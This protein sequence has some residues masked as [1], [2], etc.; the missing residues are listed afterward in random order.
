[1]VTPPPSPPPQKA[2]KEKKKKIHKECATTKAIFAESV[3]KKLAEPPPPEPEMAATTEEEGDTVD[4]EIPWSEEELRMVF[5][6][7]DKD[8]DNELEVD[9]L[10]AL[11]RY[12]GAKPEPKDVAKLIKELTHYATIEWDEFMEFIRRFRELDLSILRQ[13]FK[14]AD[15]DG[16]GK[17]D[18]AEVQVLLRNMGYAPTEQTVH[19]AMDQVDSDKTGDINFREFEA[20]REYLRQTEGLN[21]ADIQGISELYLRANGGKKHDLATQEVWRI[22]MFRGYSNTPAEIAEIV[23]EVDADGSGS[24][25]FAELLKI[26]RRV[27]EIERDD[28]LRLLRK[29][30]DISGDRV[31][32]ADIVIVLN[33]L[34]YYVSEE[35]VAE[36]MESVL[37]GSDKDFLTLEELMAFLRAYRQCEGFSVEEMSE[38]TAA[39]VAEDIGKTNSVNALELGRVLRSFGFFRTLQKVQ[40]LVEEIDFD[41]S[42]ELEMNEYLKLMRQLLQGEAKKRRDVFDSLDPGR[43]GQVSVDLLPRAVTILDEVTPDREL[44]HMALSAALP[45][46]SFSINIGNFE[47][48]YKHYRKAVVEEIRKNAGYGPKE[49]IQLS[50]I[51]A[52]YDKDKSGTIERSELQKMIAQYFPDATKSRA[53][54]VEIQKVL[55]SLDTGAKSGELDFHKFVWLMRKCDDMRDKTDVL[56]EAEVVKACELTVEEVEGFRQIFS[57]VVDWTGELHLSELKE[58]L[59]RVVELNDDQT[60]ALGSIVREVHPYGREVARFPNF[61]KLVKKLTDNNLLGLNEAANRMKRRDSIRK[62]RTDTMHKI[63]GCKKTEGKRSIQ[64]KKEQEK[65]EKASEE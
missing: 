63:E 60:D 34:G 48:F 15:V 18:A 4:M 6:K 43:S 12:L 27:R 64:V 30:G 19:E 16:G 13:V 58:L 47:L 33:D 29:H 51:F 10:L 26:I 8:N 21:S 44:L 49:I 65:L 41:G 42:G 31:P 56:M 37:D 38:L 9:D 7:F 40:R 22:T 32:V 2:H 52:A 25:S 50:S 28:I 23:S 5:Y 45:P 53:Q 3:L 17:L 24:V 11:L 55:A 1:L 46:G 59:L 36:I 39:F 20:L 62:H 61:L 14:A 54:Q 57:S 35:A